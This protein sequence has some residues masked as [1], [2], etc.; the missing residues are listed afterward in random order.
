MYDH[1]SSSSSGGTA[2]SDIFGLLTITFVVLKLTG[3]INWSWWF[4]LMPLWIG[5]LV[6]ILCLL[7]I[8][9][10]ALKKER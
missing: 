7:I 2:L 1:G 5:I 8:V 3:V 10:I 4:V 9:A 6:L